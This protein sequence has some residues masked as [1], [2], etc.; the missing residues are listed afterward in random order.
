MYLVTPFLKHVAYPSFGHLGY[1]RR[2]RTRQT[3]QLTVLTYHG[4]FPEGYKQRNKLLDGNLISADKLHRQLKLLRSHY[5][6]IAP[7]DFRLHLQGKIAL[8]PRAMLLTCDDG[9]SNVVS[10]MLPV[11]QDLGL[12]C[13]FFL[14]G[15]SFSENPGMLWHEELWLTLEAGSGR[16]IDFHHPVANI[17]EVPAAEQ[18]T[19]EFWWKLVCELSR[20]KTS[21]RKQF[22]HELQ[23][24]IGLKK[25]WKTELLQGKAE[26]KRFQLLSKSQVEEL[27]HAGMT[28]GAHTMTHPVLAQCTQEEM[29]QEISQP[30]KLAANE[31]RIPVWAFAYPFGTAETVS[32]REINFAQAVGY[33]CAFMNTGGSLLLATNRLALPRIHITADMTL[34]EFEA[35][36]T[37]FHQHLKNK[38]QTSNDAVF[39]SAALQQP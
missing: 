18:Q 1:F 27:L 5:N 14:T 12:K 23:M 31:L 16:V 39:S 36:A 24:A 38:R 4:V 35:H 25:S 20:T 17:R 34:G 8:P 28:I 10:D 11:L 7:D 13:L 30:A 32:A 6:L 21:A 3:S 19:H 29:E 37:G 26:Q 33:F 2:W 15:A 22:L 9:L